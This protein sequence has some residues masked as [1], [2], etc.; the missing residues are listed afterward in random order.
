MKLMLASTMGNPAYLPSSPTA[1]HAL[2]Y[3]LADALSYASAA[4]TERPQ[5]RHPE[6][7]DYIRSTLVDYLD[8]LSSGNMIP[9]M[10][11][12]WDRYFIP[13]DSNSD[14]PAP[15]SV[16][17]FCVLEA[18]CRS[19]MVSSDTSH[20]SG[21]FATALAK[22]TYIVQDL[23]PVSM[24]RIIFITSDINDHHPFYSEIL[25]RARCACEKILC[26]RPLCIIGSR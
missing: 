15:L 10:G 9:L 12:G 22:R 13:A 8:K 21:V 14:P 4:T 3:T 23:L 2:V 11:K 17:R 25:G 24:E 16:A 1:F 26:Y 5:S 19:L 6:E 7:Y 18:L 20:S